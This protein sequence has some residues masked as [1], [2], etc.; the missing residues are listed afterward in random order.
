MHLRPYRVLLWTGF[1]LLAI[2]LGLE[3]R[4][5]TRGWEAFLLGR[6]PGW[7][8]AADPSYGPRPGFPF[9]SR[10]FAAEDQPAGPRLWVASSSYGEDTQLPPGEIFPNLLGELI[11]A[12]VLNA[13]QAGFSVGSNT[14]QLRELG[15]T[16]HPKTVVLYQMSNDIDDISQAQARGQALGE[17]G[18]T[19]GQGE[20]SSGNPISH[21]IA[22]WTE[23]LTV[24]K[25]LKMQ[26][27]TRL[28]LAR[29]LHGGIGPGGAAEFRARVERFIQTARDLGTRPVLCTFA[30]SHTLGTL[31]D[32]PASYRQQVLAMNVELSVEGW[33]AAVEDLNRVLREL[34]AEQDLVLADVA[35]AV[36]DRPELFRDL[37]HLTAEG[38]QAA[39]AAI[40]AALGETAGER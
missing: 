39:A 28:A 30:T 32:V 13:S 26:V 18:G 36:G 27:T 5:L 31:A 3:V 8:T 24:Y 15:P 17:G 38:H 37:W 40:A 14:E 21:R 33:L 20:T 2:E 25:H 12:R 29:P 35:A 7:Q 34:A 23:Q 9:R 19:P 11:G 6:E 22:T 4:A 1:F 16:W 10:V